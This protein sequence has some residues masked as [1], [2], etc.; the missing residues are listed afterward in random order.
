M[1]PPFSSP[2]PSHLLSTPIPTPSAASF[3]STQR[4]RPLSLLLRTTPLV[5]CRSLHPRHTDLSHPL[6]HSADE[7][8]RLVRSFVNVVNHMIIH[9]LNFLFTHGET[10][11]WRVSFSTTAPI[12]WSTAAMDRPDVHLQSAMSIATAPIRGIIFC[13]VVGLPLPFVDNHCV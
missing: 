9:V 13:T 4:R 2:P 12:S 3:P 10:L 1:L 5:P 11:Q 7:V 6:P 8:D